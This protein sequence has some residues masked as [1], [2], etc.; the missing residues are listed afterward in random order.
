[1]GISI[2]GF[3]IYWV[4]SLKARTLQ[5]GILRAMGLKQSHVVLMLILEQGLISGAAIIAGILIGNLA[6]LLFVP[7]L[8]LTSSAASQVPPFRIVASQGDFLKVLIVAVAMLLAGSLLFRWMISRIRI[9][10]AIK[11]G[12]E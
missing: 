6:S 1:M 2:V 3:L 5:F 9:H 12:E 8:Q 7:L 10:Q 11:L 4:L